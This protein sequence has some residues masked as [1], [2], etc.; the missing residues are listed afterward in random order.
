LYQ[1]QVVIEGNLMR[2]PE[3]NMI[4]NG[5]YVCNIRVALNKDKDKDEHRVY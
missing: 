5:T 3:S 4:P 2:D 1:G